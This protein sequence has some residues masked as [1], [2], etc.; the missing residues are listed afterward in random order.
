L[1]KNGRDGRSVNQ[2]LLLLLPFGAQLHPAPTATFSDLPDAAIVPSAPTNPQMQP[3]PDRIGRLPVQVAAAPPPTHLLLQMPPLAFPS[4]ALLT[5]LPPVSVGATNPPPR[6][7]TTVS[8][9]NLNMATSKTHHSAKVEANRATHRVVL[10]MPCPTGVRSCTPA[11]QL[12]GSSC[13][14]L[15][16]DT[17]KKLRPQAEVEIKNRCSCTFWRA[18]CPHPP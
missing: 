7:A 3:E 11:H 1:W 10:A 5:S 2:N 15:P 13:P 6:H 14:T 4:C 9:T 18:A 17:Q 16:A 12:R 8:L